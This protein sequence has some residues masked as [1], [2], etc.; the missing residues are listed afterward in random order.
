MIELGDSNEL[1]VKLGGGSNKLVVELGGSNV[2]VVELVDNIWMVECDAET[3]GYDV[4]LDC[5]GCCI[6]ARTSFTS[7][8]Q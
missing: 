4:D 7:P 6:E 8:S 2:L 3:G 5:E 1:V